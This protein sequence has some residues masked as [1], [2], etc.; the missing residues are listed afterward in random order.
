MNR[1]KIIYWVATVVAC[2]MMSFSASMYF[3]NTYTV[4]G[5]FTQFGYP[6][7]LVIPLAT[8]KVLGI[9]AILSRK[10]TW[11]KEWAYAGFFFDGI[12]ATAAHLSAGDGG[13]IMALV[14]VTATLVSYF[15]EKKLFNLQQ[16]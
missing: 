10:I 6:S 8:A 3:M 12:L 14:L 2:G 16:V 15:M 5:F 4:K 9:V 7:Y 13:H 1:D 11:L